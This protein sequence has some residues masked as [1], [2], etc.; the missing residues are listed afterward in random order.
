[1]VFAL[2]GFRQGVGSV[3][4]SAGGRLWAAASWDGS[5][6][7][8]DI[9]DKKE[10]ATL[11]GHKAAVGNVAFSADSGTLASSG[12]DGLKLWNMATGREIITFKAVVGGTFVRF[13]PDGRTLAAGADSDNIVHLWR[14][15]MVSQIDAADKVNRPQ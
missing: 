12:I 11:T 10:L 14:A 2:G 4:I 15:P 3:A 5:I 7:V 6:K 8:G 1:M 13:S 9:A